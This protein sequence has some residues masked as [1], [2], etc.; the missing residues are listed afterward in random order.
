MDVDLTPLSEPD[1]ETLSPVGISAELVFPGT[2]TDPG[3][4]SV[5]T[6]DHLLSEHILGSIPLWEAKGRPTGAKRASYQK[7]IY[8]DVWR[9]GRLCKVSLVVYGSGDLGLPNSIDLEFFRG[10]NGG[11]KPR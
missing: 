11:R 1:E 10:L 4:L 3:S 9:N 2:L 5:T 7:Q 6:P 8:R